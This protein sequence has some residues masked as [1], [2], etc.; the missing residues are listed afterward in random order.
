VQYK[1]YSITSKFYNKHKESRLK[2]ARGVLRQEI[3]LHNKY[4]IKNT[5]G[6]DDPT[7]IDIDFEWI[8]ATLEKDLEQLK[9]NN[10]ITYNRDLSLGV[11]VSTYGRVKGYRLH[12]YF[13]ERQT[14]T[15]E[16]F[17]REGCNKRNIQRWDKQITDAGITLCML[18][19]DDPL[20]G[21]TISRVSNADTNEDREK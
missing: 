8:Y 10:R 11:L 12:S 19:S 2:V 13:L 16:Q 21:L 6:K 14:K 5:M 9:V 17:I 7:L 20:P 15:Q 3:T 4:V 18:D 1:T